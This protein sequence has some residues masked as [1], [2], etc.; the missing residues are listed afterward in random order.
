MDLREFKLSKRDFR[1]IRELLSVALERDFVLGLE[2]AESTISKWRAEKPESARD[3]YHKVLE[4]LKKHRKELARTYDDLSKFSMEMSV[5]TSLVEG[6]L[7]EAD[8]EI[9]RPE[10]REYFRLLVGRRV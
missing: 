9:M 3:A 10:A 1:D 5:T 2:Q 6:I 7:T 4:D 8:L